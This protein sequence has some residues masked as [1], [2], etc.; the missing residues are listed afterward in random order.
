MSIKKKLLLF[1]LVIGL[2]LILFAVWY[3]YTY[4]MDKAEQFQVNTSSLH[5]K[6]LI[7]TQ[8]SD[9]KNSVTQKI[10]NHYK[11]DSIFIKVIDISELPKIDTENYSAI[12]LIH[13]W[14]NWEPPLDIK[15]FIER[16]E[17]YKEKIIVLT[18][19]GKGSF[20]MD[21]IDAITGESILEDTA[22]VSNQ[23][24][25]KLAPLLKNKTLKV[26]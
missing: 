15:T 12:V 1:T 8:G 2:L 7:A 17:S 25:E 13:T 19:S 5:V 9:F 26:N 4:A 11:K 18:T 3:K 14:E 23:I 24:I 10:V 6:L 16:T 22:L 21:N 20:K